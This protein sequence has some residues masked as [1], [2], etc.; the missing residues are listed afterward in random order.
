MHE[1]ER[2]HGPMKIWNRPRIKKRLTDEIHFRALEG[3]QLNFATLRKLS[4]IEDIRTIVDIFAKQRK[5]SDPDVAGTALIAELRKVNG[6]C[7]ALAKISS[8]IMD[9]PNPTKEEKITSDAIG[10]LVI[11]VSASAQHI[12]TMFGV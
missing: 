4:K 9:K 2:R 5:I 3:T 6:N 10:H 1:A 12:L 11:P 7:E 8:E